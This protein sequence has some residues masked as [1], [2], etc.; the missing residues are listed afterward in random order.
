LGLKMELLGGYGDDDSE[1]EDEGDKAEGALI[2]KPNSGSVLPGF[3]I[4]MPKKEN[5]A[6]SK[7]ASP[8]PS[9]SGWP[10][11]VGTAHSHRTDS[12]ATPGAVR[13][14]H[15]RFKVVSRVE[16]PVLVG[17]PAL[18]QNMP[19]DESTPNSPSRQG[20]PVTVP[21]PEKPDGEV[22]REVADRV[23]HYMRLRGKPEPVQV[24]RDLYDKKEFH[25]PGILEQ[26]MSQY[27]MIEAGT[28]YPPVRP[29][30]TSGTSFSTQSHAYSSSLRTV[31]KATPRTLALALAA[32][33]SHCSTMFGL[34][35]RNYLTQR[36]TPIFCITTSFALSPLAD[37]YKKC[38]K[39]A[40]VRLLSGLWC[41]LWWAVQRRLL[42]RGQLMQQQQRRQSL[43]ADWQMVCREKRLNGTA[44]TKSP[45]LLSPLI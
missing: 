6:G 41:M 28:N 39:Q 34:L 26:L 23:E 22:D 30:P 9:A 43:P 14:R 18:W 33:A 45:N 20:E 42:G 40:M 16:T 3:E 2:G 27:T 36:S 32:G 44:Q 37:G 21:L 7:T 10:E 12:D 15:H 13:P 25:N 38:Q 24:N 5:D 4:F 35:G 17:S 31:Y 1:H 8:V 11:L 19:S 29:P